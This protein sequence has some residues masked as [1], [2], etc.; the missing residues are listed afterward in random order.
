MI[1]PRPFIKSFFALLS[2]NVIAQLLPFLFAPVLSRIFSEEEFAVQANFIAIITLIGIIAGGRYEFAIVLPKSKKDALSLLS[3]AVRIAVVVALASSAVIL[4]S[5]EISRFYED[6]QLQNYLPYVPVAVLMLAL[7]S[8]IMQWMVRRKAFKFISIVKIIQAVL[9]NTVTIVL[10]FVLFGASGLI[11]GWLLGLGI[12]TVLAIYFMKS[13]VNVRSIKKEDRLRVAKAYKDFPLINS[14]H[15]FTDIL[16]SQFL[17]FALITK[18]FGL[19]YLGLFFM[20][21]KYLRAPIKVIGS[22]VGQVYYREANEKF[23]NREAVYPLVLKSVKLVLYFA[24]PICLILIAFGP[25]LFGLYLGEKWTQSGHYARIMAIPILFNFIV[26]PISS[27][28]LIYDKQKTAFII[29]V[30][31]YALSL[32]ALMIGV[33]MKWTFEESLVLFA[34]ALSLYYLFLLFWYIYL[35]KTGNENTV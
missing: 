18:E 24:V 22:A 29:S 3:V 1:R 8:I 5:D 19:L 31:G 7:N 32:G 33:Y 23:L 13:S 10:G 16:F 30:V 15:A 35:S 14:L 2:G 9:I 34:V 17:L 11:F 28:P 4:F 26:A 12:T 6:E 21:N 25:D 27:T 20:M